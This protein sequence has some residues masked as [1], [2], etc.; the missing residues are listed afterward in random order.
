MKTKIPNVVAPAIIIF[1]AVALRL[2]PHPANVAPIGAMALFGG[3]YIGNKKYAIL[4]P[5][6]VMFV[7]DIFLGFHNTMFFV[8]GSFFL[9]GL[10][11]IWLRKRKKIQF[12]IGASLLSS[13]SFFIL[14]NFGVWFVGDLYPKTVAGLIEAYV[15][16]LPFFRNTVLGDLLYTGLFFGGYE[17]VQIVL[18]RYSL[19]LFKNK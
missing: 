11:G 2:L 1:I 7:S 13:L 18:K 3:A 10:V 12:I 19:T 17:S 5:L 14:T 9:T 6:L 15:M 16:G 4:L 8:Y